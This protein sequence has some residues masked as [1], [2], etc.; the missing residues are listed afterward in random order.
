[1]EEL[2]SKLYADY[3]WLE[4]KLK[5][6]ESGTDEYRG[7]VDAMT[8]VADRIIEIEDRVR[9]QETEGKQ[10]RSDKINQAIDTGVK[11]VKVIGSIGVPIW[12]AVVSMGFEKSDTMTYTAGKEA[13]KAGLSAMR[14]R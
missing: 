11:I 10:S 3:V 2:K 12:I 14:G 4:Q 7:Y 5:A 13:I 8:K 9:K 6:T 1:M